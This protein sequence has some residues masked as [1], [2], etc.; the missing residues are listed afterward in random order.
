MW[1]CVMHNIFSQIEIF[2]VWS[3]GGELQLKRLFHVDSIISQ[4]YLPKCR[5]ELPP[6]YILPVC[7]PAF[8][9]L[10]HGVPATCH[11]RPLT[12]VS[13]Y[14]Q[15]ASL[16]TVQKMKAKIKS[17]QTAQVQS[18]LVQ[19]LSHSMLHRLFPWAKKKHISLDNCSRR[20]HTWQLIEL[21]LTP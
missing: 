9:K 8:H 16:T 14:T 10:A 15:K 17:G 20:H 13:I 1:Q 2:S 6:N 4:S 11:L 12:S 5:N 3:Y 18:Q 7:T 21:F 19:N